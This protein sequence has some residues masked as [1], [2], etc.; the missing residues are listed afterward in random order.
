MAVSGS[1][2][3]LETIEMY[4][5]AICSRNRIELCVNE[6]IFNFMIHMSAYT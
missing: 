4:D 5:T 3:A 1:A 6:I 2:L